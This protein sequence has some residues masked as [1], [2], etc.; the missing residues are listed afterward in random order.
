MNL[1]R[2]RL[3][4]FAVLLTLAVAATEA[5]AQDLL[6]LKNTHERAANF[7]LYSTESGVWISSDGYVASQGLLS[8]LLESEKPHYLQFYV[9]GYRQPVGTFDFHSILKRSPGKAISLNI[10]YKTEERKRT[11]SVT[12]T[13]TETKTRMVPVTRMSTESKTR[14]VPVTKM[15]PVSYT[16][17][18]LPTI[19]SV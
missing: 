18:T 6:K 16:H 5:T 10:L 15:R 13:R 11:V 12:K 19:C 4:S 2:P 8:A 17:L 9:N 3:I 14:Q 1:G 7:E